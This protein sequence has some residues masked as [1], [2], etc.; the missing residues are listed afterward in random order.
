MEKTD[1]LGLFPSE[2]ADFVI[3]LG[4]PKFRAKQIYGWLMRGA[5][6]DEMS[7]LPISLRQNLAENAELR[8]P[9]VEKKLVS[10]LEKMF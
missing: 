8:L 5:E 9:K 1:I 6:F 10:E 3:S 2:L 7:N 4:E